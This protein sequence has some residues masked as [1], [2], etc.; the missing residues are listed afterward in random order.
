M[1]DFEMLLDRIARRPGIYVGRCSLWAVSCY[2]DGYCH[3]LTDEG[4]DDPQYGWSTWISL[5]YQIFHP[6]WHWTRILLH[7][8][9]S[10]Q[11]ALVQLPVLFKEFCEQGGPRRAD[12]FG[13]GL[14]KKL[15]AQ[16]GQECH[17]PETTSTRVWEE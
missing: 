15:I 12:E 17:E 7:E 11:A 10:D 13:L 5:R 9:G 14:R 1:S 16:F 4:K 3:A 6:A 8:F 2:L